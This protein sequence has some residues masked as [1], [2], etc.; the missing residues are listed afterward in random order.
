MELP[1]DVLCLVREFSKPLTRGDWRT[2]K[3]NESCHI[4]KEYQSTIAFLENLYYENAPQLY[5]MVR[6]WPMYD[7]IRM[8]KIINLVRNS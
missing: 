1:E 5:R 7:R 4:K 3:L 8:I 6:A 2:C